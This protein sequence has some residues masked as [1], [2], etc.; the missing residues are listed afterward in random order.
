MF[1]EK[2]SKT[3]QENIEKIIQV[4]QI[5]KNDLAH[6]LNLDPDELGFR[7]N[8]KSIDLLHIICVIAIKYNIPLQLFFSGIIEFSTKNTVYSDSKNI[9]LVEYFLNIKNE[10]VKKSVEEMIKSLYLEGV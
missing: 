8:M 9:K 3:I 1:K 4:N 6:A 2:I 7:L 10:K 5:D